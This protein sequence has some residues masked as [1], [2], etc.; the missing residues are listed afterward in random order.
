[1]TEKVG[2]VVNYMNEIK[3]INVIRQRINA[4]RKGGL[5]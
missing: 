4:D 5:K 1:M 3:R 2:V